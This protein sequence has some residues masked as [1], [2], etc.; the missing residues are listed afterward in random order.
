ML[1]FRSL[2]ERRHIIL[3]WNHLR[4]QRLRLSTR[5]LIL[6]HGFGPLGKHGGAIVSREPLGILLLFYLVSR[7][8]IS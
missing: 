7:I 2:I 5:R 3:A 6:H 8:Y 4:K 1:M